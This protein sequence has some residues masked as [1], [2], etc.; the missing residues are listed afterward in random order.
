[1][2][3]IIKVSIYCIYAGFFCWLIGAIGFIILSLQPREEPLSKADGI[4]VPTGASQRITRGMHLLES[5]MADKLLVTGGGKEVNYDSYL[6]LNFPGLSN[7]S[8]SKITWENSSQNTRDNALAIKD[9]THKHKIKSLII[10]T[11]N[12]H[13]YRTIAEIKYQLPDTELQVSEI[14]SNKCSFPGLIYNYG[15]FKILFLEYNKLLAFYVFKLLK[16][17]IY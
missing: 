4:V 15:C 6:S 16:V 2:K 8:R 14:N 7:S 5:Q 17:R 9:W 3:S 1:M 13:K 10:V 11:S 12:Y